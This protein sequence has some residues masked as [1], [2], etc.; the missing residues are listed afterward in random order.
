MEELQ[1][2]EQNIYQYIKNN[3]DKL[4]IDGEEKAPIIIVDLINNESSVLLN[5][6]ERSLV[7][8]NCNNNKIIP[9]LR[10]IYYL[11]KATDAKLVLDDIIKNKPE[12]ILSLGLLSLRKIFGIGE[13]Y[14]NQVVESGFIKG[15]PIV[16]TFDPYKILMHPSDSNKKVL[17]TGFS[18]AFNTLLITRVHSSNLLNTN[19]DILN[20]KKEIEK[21]NKQIEVLQNYKS[22]LD[23]MNPNF[24]TTQSK[25]EE[26]QK[27]IEQETDTIKLLLKSNK[28]KTSEIMREFS[29]NKKIDASSEI[30]LSYNQYKEFCS[31]YIDPQKEIGYDVETNA[32]P[33][34]D[35]NHEI[36]GFSLASEASS[37]CY[38][39]LKALDFKMPED[40]RNKIIED[41]KKTLQE[42]EVWV[43]N[44]QHEI[45]V[46]YNNYGIFLK[47]IKD[48]YVIIKLLNCGK[49]WESGS[50]TLKNQVKTKLDKEDWSEDLN[51]YFKLFRS[52]NKSEIQVEMKTLLAKYYEVNEV[53]DVL[54]KVIE[55]YEDIKNSFSTVKV[56]SYENVPYKLI[57]RYGSLDSS[58][59]FMLRECYYDEMEEKNDRLGIDLM[60]GFDLWQKIHIAHVMMEMN[61]LFFNDKKAQKLDDWVDSQSKDIMKQIIN[62]RLTRSWI[63]GNYWYDFSRN[64]LM[65]N[66]VDDIIN[67]QTMAKVV[68]GR[69]GITKDHIKFCNI[70]GKFIT[71]IKM[72]NKIIDDFNRLLST[73]AEFEDENTFSYIIESERKDF[74]ELFRSMNEIS[75]AK[76]FTPIK[77]EYSKGE[78]IVKINWQNFLVFYLTSKFG[79]ENKAFFE[80]SFDNWLKEQVENAKIFEDYKA[81]FNVNSTVKVFRD[82]ISNLLLS[83]PIKIAHTYYKMYEFTESASFEEDLE[84][85][86]SKNPKYESMQYN[87]VE[88]FLVMMNETKDEEVFSPKRLEIFTN[89]FDKYVDKKFLEELKYKRKIRAC[90]DWWLDESMQN[91]SDY[92]KLPTLDS[93]MI[94]HLT[95]LY[96]M[97]NCNIDDR[98]TWTEEFQFMFNY[99][100]IKKLIKAKSTYIDGSTGRGNAYYI[101]KNYY[102]KEKFPKRLGVYD[103]ANEINNVY[104]Y[105]KAIEFELEDGNKVA[106]G[107][108]DEVQL[109]D[110][111][112]K[113]AKDI[114]PEDD[115]VIPEHILMHFDTEDIEEDEEEG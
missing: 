61:G 73:N 41:L 28:L 32:L 84:S 18:M 15:V 16:P 111:T 58:S 50:R 106:Y 79:L 63:K 29:K 1:N 85:L 76:P 105:D 80:E 95:Q 56:L 22:T 9:K 69:N 72:I 20:H 90:F 77:I 66:Y 94:E 114:Q 101:D 8:E 103:P 96:M 34:M 24:D 113:L 35:V 7:E 110:G 68:Q 102:L 44:C 11:N 107:L 21:I 108:E 54:N 67:R 57:G 98:T 52:L 42:K 75:R 49:P 23:I 109:V 53:D 87:F 51:I 5:K 26:F 93:G 30:I 6:L 104:D 12:V 62:S 36:I 37:G 100:F 39:P 99:K 3:P 14:T 48:L 112:T 2:K 10:R 47:D 17:K 65:M 60:K 92:Y 86:K 45:P 82:Y 31:K 27:K 43:Y 83:R 74:K 78:F 40:D 13:S 64:V 115:I 97:L 71:M 38:V 59:L 33:V 81:L 46:V 55:R 91:V 89:L 4:Y 25:I 70:T 88:D 19:E